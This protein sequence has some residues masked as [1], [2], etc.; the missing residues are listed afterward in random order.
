MTE[1]ALAAAVGGKE[2][3]RPGEAPAVSAT[4]RAAADRLG[5]AGLAAAVRGVVEAGEDVW[6]NV[7]PTLLYWNA[8]RALRGGR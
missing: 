4:A 6:K 2:G 5:P 8:L 7:T 1:D 3:G